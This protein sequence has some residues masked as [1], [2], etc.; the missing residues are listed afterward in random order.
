MIRSC[1]VGVITSDSD[2]VGHSGNGG[3]IPPKTLTIPFLNFLA[4]GSYE[5]PRGP[6]T[7]CT[8]LDRLRGS[9]LL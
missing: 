8:W 6:K 5:K 7:G 9:G 3:S 4:P 2:A 1:S